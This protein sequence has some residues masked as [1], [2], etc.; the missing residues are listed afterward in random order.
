MD[1]SSKLSS[2]SPSKSDATSGDESAKTLSSILAALPLPPGGIKRK[3]SEDGP[4]PTLNPP[5]KVHKSGMRTE[6]V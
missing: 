1:E 4:S 2:P 6:L 5:S 3:H